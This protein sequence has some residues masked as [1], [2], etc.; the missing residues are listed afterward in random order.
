MAIMKNTVKLMAVSLF[1]L[2]ILFIFLSSNNFYGNG[3]VGFSGAATPTPPK[4]TNSSGVSGNVRSSAANSTNSVN[5]MANAVHTS[6]SANTLANANTV[7]PASGGKTI[8]KLFVLG[9]DSLSEY[10][11]APFDHDT[12]AFK[13]YSP[14]GKSIVAC[15]ECH[16]TDQPKSALKTPLFTS[17]RDVV[18]TFDVW[19]KSSQ[20]VS[21]CRDCHFQAGEVPD[22]KTMPT[23][24]GKDLDNQ[25]AYHINCNSCHDA[26]YKLRPELK[27]RK[28]FATSKDCAVCHKTS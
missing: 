14:D 7:V 6:A 3:G 8:P 27:T 23:A 28:G 5:A 21:G 26:A 1:S 10:A 25:L 11:E 19:Q 13:N 4:N 18:M 17:E 9:K 16:H 2:V 20:K 15:I 22:G 24:N 12:H